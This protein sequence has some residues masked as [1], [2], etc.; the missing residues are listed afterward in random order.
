MQN[1]NSTLSERFGVKNRQKY[2]F[3]LV[4]W[5]KGQQT[6]LLP[7]GSWGATG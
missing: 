7:L 6:H 5:P 4:I 2:I 3:D 1:Q